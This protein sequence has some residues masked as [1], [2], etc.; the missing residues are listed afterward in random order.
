MVFFTP[1]DWKTIER[2]IISS[3]GEGVGRYMFLYTV[4][5]LREGGRET[6]V[7]NSFQNP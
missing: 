5:E 2:A 4:S 3:V 7:G 6:K 1:I